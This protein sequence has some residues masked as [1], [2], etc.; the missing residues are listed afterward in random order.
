MLK[1]ETHLR[2]Q[3]VSIPLFHNPSNLLAIQTIQSAPL[4]IDLIGA[5]LFCNVYRLFAS[6]AKKAKQ[7]PELSAT[8]T[9]PH[10]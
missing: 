2:A 8:W 10:D 6:R 7:E 5:I 1:R 3:Y 9:K 4:T